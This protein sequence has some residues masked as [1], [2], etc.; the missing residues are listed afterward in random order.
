MIIQFITRL[1]QILCFV[2]PDSRLLMLF[3]FF[4]S[5]K[6]GPWYGQK[7]ISGPLP[8]W[9]ESDPTVAVSHSHSLQLHMQPGLNAEQLQNLIQTKSRS[10]WETASVTAII[11]FMQQD[12]LQSQI[13][14][15][16]SQAILP[17]AIWIVCGTDKQSVA[18]T[19]V[20]KYGRQHHGIKIKTVIVESGKQIDQRIAYG[21]SWLQVAQLA[22]S[23]YIWVIDN[24][25]APGSAYLKYLLQLAH[26]QEYQSALLGT[27][28]IIL[29]GRS[30]G[31]DSR[32]GLLCID[33]PPQSRSVDIINDVW[34]I[35]T[36]WIAQI[37]RESKP[38]ALA[39]PLGHY[40]SQALNKY[41]SIPSIVIPHEEGDHTLL[42]DTLIAKRSLNSC[43]FI[44][45][46]LQHNTIWQDFL[47]YRT[48]LSV[49][50]Y[51]KATELASSPSQDG[52]IMFVVDGQDQARALRPLFCRF[53]VLGRTMPYVVVTGESRGMTAVQLR[54]TL[55]QHIGACAN[56]DILDLDLDYGESRG[57]PTGE[58][59]P[60]AGQVS[61]DLTRL[62]SAL[63]PDLVVHVQQNA[64]PVFQGVA[65]ASKISNVMTITLPLDQVRHVL[66][67]A[68]LP[69]VAL[70]R[71]SL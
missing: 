42:A 19:M 36:Q 50:D 45:E 41:A 67:M 3:F 11:N 32:S 47:K 65:V 33:N 58:S 18:E 56:I 40:I 43:Q 63:R 69:M 25:A 2:L 16:L 21:S 46:Q 13:D 4:S 9:A 23:D 1:G 54:D 68:D 38:E 71:K 22:P 7:K 62:M 6:K 17:K 44:K 70:H 48:A 57:L 14:A 61:H 10:D 24:N 8:N 31:H 5:M 28:G 64:N 55:E 27:S 49:V 34:L 30:E 52:S 37:Y 51:A 39:S 20:S 60:L 26:T 59:A 66:W 35:R 12:S 29:P 15:V 53:H